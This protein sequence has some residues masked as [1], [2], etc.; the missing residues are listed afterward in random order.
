MEMG[1]SKKCLNKL[2]RET[3]T[4][5]KRIKTEYKISENPLSISSIGIHFLKELYTTELKEKNILII[6]T[7]EMGIL[8]MRYLVEENCTHIYIANRTSCK[9]EELK[10]RFP[11]VQ[12]VDYRKRYDVLPDMDIVICSTS[13]P[14]LILQKS[15]IPKLQKELTIMD[16]AVPRDVEASIEK[17]E[18]VQLFT[19]DALKEIAQKNMHH[20]NQIAQTIRE[21]IRREVDE[22]SQWI[23]Q[24]RVDPIIQS[25]HELCDEVAHNTFEL[26]D[27]KMSLN[28]R[29]KLFVKKVLQ[30]S[31]KRIVRTPINQLKQLKEEE[32]I[33]EYQDMINHLFHF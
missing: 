3:V 6:G 23:F 32:Q 16:L 26:M 5:A 27:K 24:S 28:H 13:S 15:H 10:D 21:R 30:S 18:G 17:I 1:S 7:G 9:A 19:V 11:M 31:L 12:T 14:H 4:F 29:E 22:L 33:R 20:R 2:F 8:A 25:F